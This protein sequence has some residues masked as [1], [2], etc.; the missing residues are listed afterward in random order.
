MLRLNMV[1]YP[2]ARTGDSTDVLAG[3]EFPDPYRWL[4]GDSEEVWQWQRAQAELAAANV[5]EW[6][7]FA[8]LQHLVRRFS[9]EQRGLVPRYAAGRWFR[10]DI[11]SG[12][13]QPRVLVTEER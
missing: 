3:V 4:E 12:E 6:S 5:R 9:T 8:R 7:H 2:H 13:C 1:N 11:S 10:S